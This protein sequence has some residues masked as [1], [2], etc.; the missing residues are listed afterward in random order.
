MVWLEEAKKVIAGFIPSDGGMTIISTAYRDKIVFLE[1]VIED[2]SG[3]RSVVWLVRFDE[4]G[5]LKSAKCY[6]E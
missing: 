6:N 5:K 3:A 2:A 1:C 4:Y